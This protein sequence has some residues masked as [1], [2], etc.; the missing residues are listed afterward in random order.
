MESPLDIPVNHSPTEVREEIHIFVSHTPY[1]YI[2]IFDYLCPG[3]CV[4]LEM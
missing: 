4:K 2:H 3:V 1:M